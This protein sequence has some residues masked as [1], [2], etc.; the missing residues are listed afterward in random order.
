M[1]IRIQPVFLVYIG[2]QVLFSSIESCFAVLT[3][4]FVH[5]L[6]HYLAAK[7]VG[8]RIESVEITPFGGVMTYSP[9]VHASKGLRGIALSA[10]GPLGNY[11]FILT[12]STPEAK[13]LLGAE[14]IRMLISSNLV[15]L[16][17]NLL[18][19]LPFDGGRIV[20]NAGYY[21]VRTALLISILSK[22]GIA[23]GMLFVMLALYGLIFYQMLNCSLILVGIYVIVCAAQSR[24]V[25][26]AE[27]LLTVVQERMTQSRKIAAMKLIYTDHSTRLYELLEP[28]QSADAC[29]FTYEDE[30]G[31]L[32]F[33][34]ETEL[35]KLMLRNPSTTI[36]QAAGNLFCR[37]NT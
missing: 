24:S 32:H 22:L 12:V 15:M 1:K 33:I 6:G 23:A 29:C 4:L 37:K 21:F 26:L 19:A 14:S 28:L 31:E 7:C 18:P 17:L 16:T 9:D 30:K 10:A 11:L 20:F 27:N 35:L 36:S 5:E 2:V 25:L 34:Q 8:E 3:A 13:N